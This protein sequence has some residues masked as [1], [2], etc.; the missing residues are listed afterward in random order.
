MANRSKNIYQPVSLGNYM[1]KAQLMAS[2][3]WKLAKPESLLYQTTPSCMRLL[4]VCSLSEEGVTGHELVLGYNI[5]EVPKSKEQIE[6]CEAW[7]NAPDDA[8]I[9]VEV[10]PDAIYYPTDIKRRCTRLG[11]YEI[12]FNMT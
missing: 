9:R 7:R 5:W 11:E 1:T 10:L 2:R 12:I 8:V 3:R 6:Q 4:S